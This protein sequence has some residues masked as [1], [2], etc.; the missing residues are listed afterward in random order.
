MA[1]YR[2]EINIHVVVNHNHNLSPRLTI[3][4]LPCADITESENLGN[5]S[6]IAQTVI[7]DGEQ[8]NI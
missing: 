6:A 5:S 2:L 3:P 1:H 8:D 4:F 7:K